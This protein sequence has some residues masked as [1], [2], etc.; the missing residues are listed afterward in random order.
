MSHVVI[1][2]PDGAQKEYP[3]GVTPMEVAMSISEGLARNVLSAKLN[4]VVVD[5]STPI[6]TNVSLQL[7]TWKDDEGKQTYWHS[8]AHLLA[9]ALE[10]LYPGIKLAIGPP[11]QNGFYY[12]IDF[13]DHKFSADD[14]EAVEKKMAELAKQSSPFQRKEVSKQDA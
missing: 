2:L 3:V 6:T 9:E 10:S 11:I 13:G 7:L 14:F 1:T 4:D 12:D 8:S 5:A